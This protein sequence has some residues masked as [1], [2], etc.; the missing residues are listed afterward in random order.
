ME[1]EVTTQHLIGACFAG[2]RQSAGA[3]PCHRRRQKPFFYLMK[4][5]RATSKSALVCIA[6][7]RGPR[8]G[9]WAG[10]AAVDVDIEDLAGTGPDGARVTSERRGMLPTAP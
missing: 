3:E 5:L 7:S 1:L 10:M 6:T 9:S 8:P 2:I 4:P